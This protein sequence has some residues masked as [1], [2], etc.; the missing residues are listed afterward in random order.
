MSDACCGCCENKVSNVFNNWPLSGV[1]SAA[2]S[3]HG[4]GAGEGGE[5]AR[6][7]VTREYENQKR[8]SAS[9][10]CCSSLFSIPQIPNTKAKRKYNFI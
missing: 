8:F 3:T 4:E 5:R 10:T 6:L 1:K 2:A 9:A 7:R